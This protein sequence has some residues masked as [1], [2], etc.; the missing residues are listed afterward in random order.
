MPS[1]AIPCPPITPCNPCICAMDR[2]SEVKGLRGSESSRRQGRLPILPSRPRRPLRAGR[3]MTRES[4]RVTRGKGALH[5]RPDP[6]IARAPR[7]V[8]SSACPPVCLLAESDRRDGSPA[9]S[10]RANVPHSQGSRMSRAVEQS[11]RVGPPPKSNEGPGMTQSCT[12]QEVRGGRPSKAE[13]WIGG[14]AGQGGPDGQFSTTA[15][16][17]SASGL[18]ARQAWASSARLHIPTT[19]RQG[20]LLLALGG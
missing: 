18:A 12:S 16:A 2:R 13:R 4:V 5:Q 1:H 20:S 19:C 9:R 7:W 8:W 17:Y 11:P 6:V 3:G 14:Q 15:K 10:V